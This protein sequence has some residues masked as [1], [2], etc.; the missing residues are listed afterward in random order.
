MYC[1]VISFVVV[2]CTAVSFISNCHVACVLYLTN[3][4]CMCVR[5]RW[6]KGGMLFVVSVGSGGKDVVNLVPWTSL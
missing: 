6:H 4:T 1:I 3:V 2:C 5:N